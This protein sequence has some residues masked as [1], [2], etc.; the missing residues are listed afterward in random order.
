[1][2]EILER[3]V[4]EVMGKGHSESSAYAICRVSLGLLSDGT[5]DASSIEL[6][7]EELK[8]KLEMTLPFQNGPLLLKRMVIA[9]PFGKFVNGD[10]EGNMT[11]RRLAGLVENYKKYPRQVPV[12]MLGEHEFD[13]DGFVPVGWVEGLEQD[14]EGNLVARVK[15][16]GMGAEAVGADL[17]RGASI[18]TVNGK[19]T[20]GT[21]IGEVLK[22]LLLTNEPFDKLVNIAA[23]HE[24]GGERVVYYATALSSETSMP[25]KDKSKDSPPDKDKQRVNPNAEEPTVADLKA[26]DD[27]I[28]ALKAKLIQAEEA[29]EELKEQIATAP[30][31]VEKEELAV[32]VRQL[33]MKSEAQEI[34]E[35]VQSGLQGGRLKPS[36]CDGF[37]AGKGAA[38]DKATTD[39]L[40]SHP[41]FQGDIKLL[42]WAVENSEPMYRIGKTFNTGAPAQEKALTADDKA[43]MK[44]LGLKPET[45]E[46]VMKAET[47]EEARAA[48]SGKED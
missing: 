48:F 36:W 4:S 22:H 2:P 41:K 25:D 35:L 24:Q 40:K 15:L 10:Q 20:D 17:I 38:R 1:M 12:K 19:D 29:I 5:E 8:A 44:K 31:D 34:R 3:C 46:A 16:H 7:E 11:K 21:A 42:R 13:N 23:S 30:Q 9:H 33:E 32:K 6:S 28:V 39:W 45:V 37:N 43:L 47:T 26:K 18:G 14:S 27:E